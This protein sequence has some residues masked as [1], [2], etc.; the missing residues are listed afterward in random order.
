[1]FLRK[2]R[3]MVENPMRKNSRYSAFLCTFRADK[4]VWN[5]NDKIAICLLKAIHDGVITAAEA[6]KYAAIY[7]IIM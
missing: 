5:M 4:E 6:E 1:M 7:G 2:Y 3:A